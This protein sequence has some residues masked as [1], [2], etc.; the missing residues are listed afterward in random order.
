MPGADGKAALDMADQEHKTRNIEAA[1]EDAV[2]KLVTIRQSSLGTYVHLPIFYPS[3]AAATVLVSAEGGAFRVSDAGFAYREAELVGAKPGFAK[4]AKRI[5]EDLGL[6]MTSRTISSLSTD[7]QLS[8][9]IADVAQASAA[10]ANGIIAGLMGSPEIELAEHLAERLTAVFGDRKIDFDATIP[11]AS[12]RA[13]DVSA[14]VRLDERRVIF[15]AVSNNAVAVY[16]T[17]TK[18]RDI[19]LLERA[20]ATVSVIRSINEMGNLYNILAQSGTVIQ[21]DA[22]GSAF[23]RAAAT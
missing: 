3:G 19:A 23:E 7:W 18:F 13:W 15:D 1:V 5:S 16:S 2:E 17:A 11:G 8:A 10:V 9:T 4:W 20:P 22:P 21:E 12:T 14:V 6:E